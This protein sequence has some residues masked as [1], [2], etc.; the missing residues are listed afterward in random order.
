M[1]QLNKDD[2]A[3]WGKTVASEIAGPAETS[4]SPGVKVFTTA[5]QCW[6]SELPSRCSPQQMEEATRAYAARRPEFNL[7]TNNCARFACSMLALCGGAEATSSEAVNLLSN[8]SAAATAPPTCH[9]DVCA[10][11]L[12][13]EG[14]KGEPGCGMHAVST[15]LADHMAGHAQFLR[16][17]PASTPPAVQPAAQPVAPVAQQSGSGVLLPMGLM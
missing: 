13:F 14:P 4:A 17:A 6:G 5:S 11:H 9:P 7:L 10:D 16:A 12:M 2:V 8:R 1:E 3:E 15:N